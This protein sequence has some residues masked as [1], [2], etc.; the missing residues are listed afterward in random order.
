[1]S[2]TTERAASAPAPSTQMIGPSA[3]AGGFKRAATLAWTMAVLEFKLRFFGSV[4]GYFW[5][6]MRPLMLFGVLYVVFTQ[7]LTLGQGVLFYPVLLLTGIVIY[8]FFADA[9][10]SSVSAVLDRENI[11]RK[12]HFPRLAIP[13]AVVLSAIFNLGLN[14][15]AV[16]TF[17]AIQGVPVRAS[18]LELPFLLLYVVVFAFGLS[19]LLSAWF[20]R[21]RDVRPIWDVVL[22]ITFYASPVL[23]TIERIDIEWLKTLIL[24]LNPLAPLLVQ[25]RH[26]LVDPAA[27]SA[28]DALGGP[29][30]LLV[31]CGIVAGVFCL[32]LYVFSRAAPRIAEDL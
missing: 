22:Q 31:P 16:G 32:G 8:T 5:Q 21:Y 2:A 11:V 14:L 10:S 3:L 24:H 19:M 17:F 6:L 1:V 9:T 4:L 12:I 28:A 25:V 13:A 23:W 20:V 30:H 26:S 29:L 7:A 27:P 15:L 18:W